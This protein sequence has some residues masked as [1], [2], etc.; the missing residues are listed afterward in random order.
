MLHQ[1]PSRARHPGIGKT[2]WQAACGCAHVGHVAKKQPRLRHHASACRYGCLALQAALRCKVSH[3][4]KRDAC[5]NDDHSHL[6][7]C[8]GTMDADQE[9]HASRGSPAFASPPK[10]NPILGVADAMRRYNI[11]PSGQHFDRYC[12]ASMCIDIK[13]MGCCELHLV[14]LLHSCDFLRAASKS[15]NGCAGWQETLTNPRLSFM[16]SR[17]QAERRWKT[18]ILHL[19]VTSASRQL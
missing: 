6:V 9:L 2:G 15:R 10:A 16:T 5:C 1:A 17:K 12:C 7:L 13:H 4:F 14:V 3:C 19:S 18:Y 11:L 8:R